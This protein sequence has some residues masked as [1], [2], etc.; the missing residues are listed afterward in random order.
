MGKHR[1]RIV[2]YPKDVVNI[3]GFKLPAARKLLRQIRADLDKPP[4]AFI[5]ISE[6]A[7]YLRMPIAQILPFLDLG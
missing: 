4:R 6:F 3:T 7:S 2:I 5:T 1:Q